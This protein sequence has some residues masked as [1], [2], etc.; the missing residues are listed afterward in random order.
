M[1]AM[2]KK[3]AATVVKSMVDD[4]EA[5]EILGWVW[6]LNN[7]LGVSINVKKLE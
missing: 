2:G 1:M 4:C 3:K 7:G 6:M 5:D